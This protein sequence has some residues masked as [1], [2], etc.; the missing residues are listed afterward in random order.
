M[1]ASSAALPARGLLRDALGAV[2]SVFLVVATAAVLLVAVDSIP[3]LVTGEPRH[4]RRARTVDEVERRLRT[5][6]LVPYY[7][8]S[9]LAWPP[10]RI[11]FT[12]DPP[13]AALS[14]A[15]RD[16][17]PQV[18]LAEALG[19]GPIPARLVPE[20]QVL[21]SSPVTVGGDRGV[22][23]RV[24]VDG[25]VGWE[26]RWEQGGRRLLVRS[27]GTVEELLRMARSV[28]EGP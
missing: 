22:L 20:A 3:G 21:H 8:P 9:T 17:S 5:R 23:S 18:F 12:V 6:L 10:E 15:G 26:V 25:V 19:P 4:V 2:V 1:S 16:G 24:V 28:R 13:G 7:F 11:R 27:R 14:V